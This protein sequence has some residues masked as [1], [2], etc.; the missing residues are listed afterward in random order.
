MS[1]KIVSILIQAALWLSVVYV[2]DTLLA[3][4]AEEILVVN[5]MESRIINTQRML[6]Y[7]ICAVFV[8]T[9]L[10]YSITLWVFPTW[11]DRGK[12]PGG[13]LAVMAVAAGLLAVEYGLFSFV[14][15]EIRVSNHKQIFQEG[16][17]VAEE[18]VQAIPE[19]AAVFSFWNLALLALSAL[20]A[21]VWSFAGAWKDQQ[22]QLLE[23]QA[24][25]REHV[26]NAAAEQA[27]IP[28]PSAAMVTLKSGVEMHRVPLEEILFLKKE[29]NY[30]TV[31]TKTKKVVI[32]QNMETALQWLPADMFR[33]VHR[34]FIVSLR[35]VNVL[36]NNTLQVA[37]YEIP[38]GPGYKEGLVQSLQNAADT[39]S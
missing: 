22:L 12:L 9:I 16:Q 33:R 39:V 1:K 36:K 23:W 38:I 5:G 15:D 7:L 32:R 29:G 13:V 20:V 14:T 26:Q 34:S 35:H 18:W 11:L 3:V 21:L 10:A 37:T 30:F 19:K 6:P 25:Q 28:A 2:L 27:E 17:Q 24:W 31:Y 8:A 4:K